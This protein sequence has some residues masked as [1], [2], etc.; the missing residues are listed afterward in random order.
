MTPCYLHRAASGK[1]EEDD[2]KDSL[3]V[4]F[5]KKIHAAFYYT[6]S[7]SCSV[8]HL[9]IAVYYANWYHCLLH[10]SILLCITP[11]YCCL[12][13]KS[14]SLFINKSMSLFIKRINLAVLNKSCSKFVSFS[15]AVG[16][17]S[18]TD[19]VSKENS[20]YLVK[21][22]FY[23]TM[24]YTFCLSHKL[25]HPIIPCIINGPRSIHLIIILKKL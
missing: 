17:W 23:H 25:F 18:P 3:Q 16:S 6:K 15:E 19:T 11:R 4:T 2:P 1:A 10:K 21:C 12:L 22:R 7:I 24:S 14:I 9:D 13:H 5:L 8:L 20:T